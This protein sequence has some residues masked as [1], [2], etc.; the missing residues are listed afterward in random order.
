MDYFNWENGCEIEYGP[1]VEIRKYSTPEEI[2]KSAVSNE[3]IDAISIKCF[4]RKEVKYNVDTIELKDDMLKVNGDGYWISEIENITLSYDM[5]E[6]ETDN[7]TFSGGVYIGT[8]TK[9]LQIKTEYF[10]SLINE[11]FHEFYQGES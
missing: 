6:D 9:V 11:E 2:V 8:K 5:F 7:D 10:L 4:G 1:E 3:R